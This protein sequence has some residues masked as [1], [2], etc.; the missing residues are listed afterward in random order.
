MNSGE[1]PLRDI[2]LPNAVGWWPL[3]PGWWLLLALLIV[4]VV[5]LVFLLRKPPGTA[6]LARMAM[7]AQWRAWEH[8]R[9]ARALLV[10]L[11]QTLRRVAMA[12]DGRDAHA[13]VTG[14]RWRAFLNEPMADAPFSSH[15]GTLL[16]DAIY[17]PND[18]TLSDD[19]AAALLSLCRERVAQFERTTTEPRP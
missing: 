19:D 3:A 6:K 8:N 5:A 14:E 11:S 17:R 15:P 12:A 13:S 18:T 1:L 10:G 16:V 9:N 7:A 4:G 2:H